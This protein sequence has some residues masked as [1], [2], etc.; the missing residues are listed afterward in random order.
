MSRTGFPAPVIITTTQELSLL[1]ERL[2]NEPFITIDT[3]FVRE[4]T[5]W[6]E[7][8]LVQLG[9][10]EDVALVDCCVSDLDLAPLKD[11]LDTASCLKVFHAAR[12][13]LEIFLHL[14]DA[15][16][17]PLF[18]T[19]VAAMVCGYGEQVGYDKLVAAITGA[20]IDKT[21][22]FSD[23]AARPLSKAQIAYAAA[24]VTHLRE[25]YQ[26][27]HDELHDNGRVHWAD[28]ELAVLN[29]PRT[30]RPDPYRQWERL[31]ARTNNPRVLGVLRELAAWRENEAQA[32]NVPRQRVLRDEC[33][34]ELA[35]VR[36]Q[37]IEALTQIR[38]VSKGFAEGKTAPRLLNALA[39]GLEL[40]EDA[41]P[42]PRRKPEGGQ[43][44]AAVVAL[45][46][47]LLAAQCEAHHVAPKLVATS[48]DLDA[49]ALGETESAVLQGW[50]RSVF[51]EQALAL[52][53]GEIHL[54]VQG[55]A[56]A[57]LPQ[58]PDA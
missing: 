55:N 39:R 20:T 25:V 49:L 46:K 12:Q 29:D 47:V 32:A 4:H 30:F 1:C 15:L 10:T 58:A 22:R 19:Q 7:L 34:I 52:L 5:Y 48:D 50:R 41:L 43:P 9:G 36:P 33:L 44:S 14:F 2:K 23:W 31:K 42:A 37:T 8:C 27:L 3:E 28:A 38:G 13:D 11:L 17:R 6:P 53:R 45:L 16:P 24:D 51:G 35:A 40:P 54:T 57:I 56:I 18:D 26:K 21:H